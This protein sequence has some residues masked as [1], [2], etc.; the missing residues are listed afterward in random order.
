MHTS[1]RKSDGLRGVVTPLRFVGDDRAL[2]QALRAQHPGA[3]VA[4]YDEHAA[5]VHRVLRSAVGANAELPDLLQEVFVRAVHGIRDLDELERVRSWLTSVAVYT[6]RAYIRRRARRRWLGLFS[7]RGRESAGR[8]RTTGNSVVAD[9]YRLLDRL[10]VEQRL[11][12][13]LRIVHGMTLPEAA[14]ATGVSVATF[15]SR[16]AR[17]QKAFLEAARCHPALLEWLERGT[18]W[19]LQKQG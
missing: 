17:A 2:L 3:I 19:N 8:Q 18:P 12:F 16:L 5:Y 15:K 11:A 6:A 10:P 9:V 1:R 14:E 13:A 4:F 7:R